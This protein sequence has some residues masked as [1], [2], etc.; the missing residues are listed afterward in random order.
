MRRTSL[1]TNLSHE[2]HG[3]HFK[4]SAATVEQLKG[5]F[6]EMMATKMRT[7]TPLL[8]GLISTLLDSNQDCQRAMIYSDGMT[9][10]LGS[11]AE[12]DL[13]E[14]GGEGMD[15]ES[16]G[17]T[18][19]KTKKHVH[20]AERNAALISIKAVV[21]ISIMLQNS[22]ERCNYL[23][24]ILGFFYHSTLV[25]EKV[26]ETLA[27]AGL[28]ISISSIH[29]AVQS[30]SHQASA[31][32]RRAIRS[33]QSAFAY[34]NVDI[35]FKTEQPTLEHHSNFVSATSTTVIPLF[36]V[37]SAE[38]FAW[39]AWEI[40][41]HH[42][43]HF[44]HFEKELCEPAPVERIPLHKTEQ[45]PC[46][47]MNIK[48]STTDGNVEVMENLLHQ[49][50]IRDKNSNDFDQSHDIDMSEHVLLVHG[51]LLTKEWLDTVGDSRIIETTP[52]NCLHQ[53][54]AGMTR[55]ACFSQWGTC[56]QMKPRRWLASLDFDV[57]MKSYITTFKHRCLTAGDLKHRA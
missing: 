1:Y 57:C 8:W 21:C 19:M 54:K 17:N 48:Q 22:N 55:I 16:G 10:S 40:L 12:M 56:D 44:Q 46:R 18:K 9:S 36:G 34:D 30:V 38:A 52:K 28:S 6:M 26:I 47:V 42:G 7:V 24:G 50:G 3:L 5:Q 37:N 43:Q 27:H 14:F 35:D 20:A 11:E 29:N 25:P 31:R 33:L 32:I 2:R 49:G 45:V 23:Q 51:D 53:R 39:H 15:G 4:A 41:V 13:G